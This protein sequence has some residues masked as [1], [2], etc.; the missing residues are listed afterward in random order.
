M[1]AANTGYFF[2]RVNK[3]IT[4][5]HTSFRSLQLWNMID[6]NFKSMP[7]VFFKKC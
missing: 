2:T 6:Q 3:S 5:N 1:Q 7:W 4:K